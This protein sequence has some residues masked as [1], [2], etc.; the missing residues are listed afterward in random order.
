MVHLLGTPQA[1]IPILTGFTEPE[2]PETRKRID[3][4]NYVNVYPFAWKNFS[5]NGYVTAFAEDTPATGIFTYRLTGFKEE[6]TDHYMRPFHVE[7]NKVIGKHPKY[8]LGSLPR[9]KV[10][11]NWAKQLFQ[12]YKD[13]PKFA[14]LFHGELSHDDYNIVQYADDDFM[15]TLSYLKNNGFLDNTLLILMSDHGH[16]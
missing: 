9:H 11:F 10:M 16:R 12:V 5:Q 3:N 13:V 6:P 2:L 7:A 1:L 4:A 14:F 8:C 15:E